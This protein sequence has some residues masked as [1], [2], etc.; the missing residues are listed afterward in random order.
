MAGYGV[1]TLSVQQAMDCTANP[2]DCGGSG[3]CGG[4]TAETVF[5]SIARRGGI[6]SEWTY[7]YNNYYGKIPTQACKFNNSKGA[8]PAVATLSGYVSVPSNNYTA[9]MDALSQGPLVINVDAAAWVDY[10]G[11]VYT[12]C[13]AGDVDIDHVVV[14]AGYGTDATTG[15]DY[16]LVMNSWGANYGEKGFIRIAR[17][18]SPTCAVDKTPAD[19]TGCNGGPSQVNVCGECGILYDALYPTGVR[20]V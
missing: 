3:G 13:S 15:Q 17:S 12:G 14:L 19:G 11:G 7:Y 2:L 6:A 20:L 10:A 1:P 8:T 9:V 18:S 5:D 4:G 16:W